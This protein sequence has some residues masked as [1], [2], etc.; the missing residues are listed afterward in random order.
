M[1]LPSS[2][3]ISLND[4]RNELGTTGKI[5]LND[6]EVRDLAGKSSG[7]IKLSDFY[8]K[9][10][11]IV[12]I[13]LTIG[14]QYEDLAQYVSMDCYGF[15]NSPESSPPIVYGK[16]N[17]ISYLGG[18]F[19]I[20]GGS[21]YQI[22]DGGKSGDDFSLENITEKPE[23]ILMTLPNQQEIIF[24]YNADI[25]NETIVYYSSNSTNPL[26]SYIYNLV[27]ETIKIQLSI[28]K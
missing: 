4:I 27:G 7:T 2:G 5:S 9:S 8:G 21:I 6:K 19:R 26:L 3:K 16:I 25:S 13:E 22:Y 24:T 15:C 1:S 10:G 20:L 17:P 28:I 12:T 23:Q 18:T 11:D 14:H